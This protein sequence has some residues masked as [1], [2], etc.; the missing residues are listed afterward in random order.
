MLKAGGFLSFEIG[1]DQ[2]ERM[3]ALAQ[4]SG[5][6]AEILKDLSGNS[7]VALLFPK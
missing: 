4:E 7:R 1:Y 6:D 3:R 2:A 5:Y